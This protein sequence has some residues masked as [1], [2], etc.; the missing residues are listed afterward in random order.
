MPIIYGILY[1]NVKIGKNF[2][3][4]SGAVIRED[5]IIGENFKLWTNSVVD[6]GVR[7]GNN[8]KIHC[9]CYIAQYTIIED[10]VFLA[11]GVICANDMYP[12]SSKKVKLVGVTLKKHCQIGCN[13]TL[14]P[15]VVVGKN[16]IIGAGS[17]V[18]R[19]IPANVIAYGNPCR[20]MRKLK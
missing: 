19:N 7:I 5:C 15:G 12:G 10:D 11:P 20:A 18:T 4:G 3:L 14:L 1:P 9:L 2:Q 6:Y 8:V 17:V 16:S 13:V